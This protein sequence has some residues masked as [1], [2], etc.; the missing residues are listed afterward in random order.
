MQYVAVLSAS[1]KPL[2]PTNSV[3]A[4][5]LLKRKK[6]VIEKYSPVFTIR[7]IERM[8]GDVQPV[9]LKCD[10]GYAHIGVSIASESKEYVNEQRD[11]LKTENGSIKKSALQSEIDSL[12]KD[13]EALN[14]ELLPIKKNIKMLDNIRYC[15]NQIKAETLGSDTDEIPKSESIKETE[16]PAK[17]QP[18]PQKKESVLVKLSKAKTQVDQNKNNS[19]TVRHTGQEL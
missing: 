19:R 8:D 17:T 18:E 6:A 7:L 13:I 4:R 5:K 14:A 12:T 16:A 15:V 9:E 1:G 3:R 11:L 10:A 2:M